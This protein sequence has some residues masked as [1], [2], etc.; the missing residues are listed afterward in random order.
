MK[1]KEIQLAMLEQ[2]R[3]KIE[4]HMSHDIDIMG[5]SAYNEDTQEYETFY[6]GSGNPTYC[7]FKLAEIF[8]SMKHSFEYKHDL[9]QSLDMSLPE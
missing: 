5:F 3:K 9:A 4:L 6:K 8:M 2:L 7:D 1:N